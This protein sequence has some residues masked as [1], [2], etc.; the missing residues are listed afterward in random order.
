V[1]KKNV[2]SSI[3]NYNDDHDFVTKPTTTTKV[4]LCNFMQLMHITFNF[5]ACLPS[6]VGSSQSEKNTQKYGVLQAA[7]E[8]SEE[9]N[10]LQVERK[11]CG[12][13]QVG[14]TAPSRQLH[15]VVSE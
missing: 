11:K 15:I 13:S 4:L 2:V 6:A 9:I 8:E 3:H 7:A 1:R 14:L 12:I 5:F 10:Y